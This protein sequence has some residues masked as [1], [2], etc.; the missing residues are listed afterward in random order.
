MIGLV[1]FGLATNT[2]KQ[3]LT[4]LHVMLQLQLNND[5]S[6]D[7]LQLGRVRCIFV[8]KYSNQH[9]VLQLQV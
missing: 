3:Q 6:G 8:C 1:L 7:Q 4:K 5:Q 9:G 2:C